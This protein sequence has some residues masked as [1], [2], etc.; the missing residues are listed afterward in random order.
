MK[1]SLYLLVFI[2]LFNSFD[3]SAQLIV[4]ESFESIMVAGT[5][6][7][8]CGCVNLPDQFSDG[9]NDYYGRQT[10]AT[11]TA[12]GTNDYMGENCSDLPRRRRSR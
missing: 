10:D 1:K 2:L 7:G 6:Q 9:G 5:G 8:D 3:I 12:N 4:T 11:I